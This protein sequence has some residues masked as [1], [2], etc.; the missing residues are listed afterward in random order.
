MI[1]RQKREQME[2]VAPP[3]T[4]YF[5]E[6]ALTTLLQAISIEPYQTEVYITMSD[7]TDTGTFVCSL[8]PVAEA[9]GMTYTIRCL[10]IAD[11]GTIT[12]F[13]GV[14]L[15]DSY[16]WSDLTVNADGE[17]CIVRSDGRQWHVLVTDM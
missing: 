2:T 17:Y 6:S 7:G 15:S 3:D 11:G 14:G 12:D 9:K 1:T 4:R 8:P 16:E 10:D 5:F 13:G